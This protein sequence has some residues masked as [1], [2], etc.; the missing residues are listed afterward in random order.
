MPKKSVAMKHNSRDSE[1][2]KETRQVYARWIGLLPPSVSNIKPTKQSNRLADSN[3]H[4]PVNADA[5]FVGWQDTPSGSVLAL[6]NV[7]VKNHPLYLSTVSANTLR[8]QNLQIP[9]TPSM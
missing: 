6:Y 9:P 4:K 5:V 2:E 3:N 7:T 1:Q 8:E